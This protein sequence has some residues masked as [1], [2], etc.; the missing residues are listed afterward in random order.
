MQTTDARAAAAAGTLRIGGELEVNRLGFGSMRLTGPGSFGPPRD[1]AEARRVLRRAVELGVTFI[2]TAAAYGPGIA[3]EIIAEALHPY[4]QDLVIATKGGL[5]I[6]GPGQLWPE[7]RPEDL[8]AGC[9]AS[10]RRL[11]VDRIDLYQLHRRDPAVPFEQQLETLRELQQEG[12][13]RFIGLSQIDVGE[14]EAARRTTQIVSVQ[15]LYN[16]AE[17]AADPLVDACEQA[18][19]AFI[20][21]FP[22]ATGQLA[23]PASPLTRLAR[24]YGGSASQVALAWLLQRSPAMLPI[25]GTSTVEHLE[26]NIAGAALTLTEHEHGEL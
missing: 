8:R 13:I 25:P 22:L 7:G 9:E 23:G 14:L 26:E 24:R 17:R 4:P 2:D 12:K 20:P 6:G 11:R 15:N 18:G 5:A 10:L 21:W 3:E 1:R 19:I 16:L